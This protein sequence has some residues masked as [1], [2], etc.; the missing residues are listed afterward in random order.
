MRQWTTTAQISASRASHQP[1]RN[2]M[3]APFPSLF[4]ITDRASEEKRSGAIEIG[5]RDMIIAMCHRPRDWLRV[6]PAWVRGR[7]RCKMQ[8]LSRSADSHKPPTFVAVINLHQS[9][10]IFNHPSASRR[11]LLAII[12]S[13]LAIPITTT[14]LRASRPSTSRPF[15]YPRLVCVARQCPPSATPG[16][17]H[18]QQVTRPTSDGAALTLQTLAIGRLHQHRSAA[19]L[20]PNLPS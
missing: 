15:R 17:W 1:N 16:D 2:R 6:P 10:P 4:S 14:R 9:S 20:P 13:T 8:S 11:S 19:R 3:H 7:P 5:Y 18:R 12:I